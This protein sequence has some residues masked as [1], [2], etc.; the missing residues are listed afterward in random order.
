MWLCDSWVHPGQVARS[1]YVWFLKY[2]V[3]FQNKKISS[4]YEYSFK[5]QQI[6]FC[7]KKLLFWKITK[8]WLTLWSELMLRVFFTSLLS[9][10][11]LK[12]VSTDSRLHTRVVHSH[13]SAH[14]KHISALPCPLSLIRFFF[15]FFLAIW[16]VMGFGLILFA[17]DCRCTFITYLSPSLSQDDQRGSG[18]VYGAKNVFIPA[19]ANT[20][21]QHSQTFPC[22]LYTAP[23]N[24]ISFSDCSLLPVRRKLPVSVC[25]SGLNDFVC[26]LFIYFYHFL[27]KSHPSSKSLILPGNNKETGGEAEG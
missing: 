26:Y 6:L 20:Q 27:I 10:A 16:L 15:F 18:V 2:N 7:Y 13:T 9:S 14:L 4:K 25:F 11:F 12:T 19:N 5:E 23:L 3:L 8:S 1:Y 24:N 21:Q 22:L 17:P